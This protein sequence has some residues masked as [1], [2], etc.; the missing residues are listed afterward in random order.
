[1]ARYSLLFLFPLV[2]S[3]PGCF[4][5]KWETFFQGISSFLPLCLVCVEEAM[6]SLV[7]VIV[8]SF[9]F[10]TCKHD[11]CIKALFSFWSQLFRTLKKHLCCFCSYD[12]LPTPPN[13]PI[14]PPKTYS[15]PTITNAAHKLYQTQRERNHIPFEQVVPLLEV[16]E[17]YREALFCALHL[18]AGIPGWAPDNEQC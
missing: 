7:P 10:S 12:H 11:G 3:P 18:Q 6:E 5:R 2:L 16:A 17:R 14:H 15:C 13:P 8:F 9:P 4:T 1:M